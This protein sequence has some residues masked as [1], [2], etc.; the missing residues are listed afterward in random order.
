MKQTTEIS[1][2]AFSILS[3]ILI[4]MRH[5][6]KAAHLGDLGFAVLPFLHQL[7][8]LFDALFQ[9]VIHGRHLDGF[10]KIAVQRR[11]GHVGNVGD[12]FKSQLLIQIVLDVFQQPTKQNMFFEN[13]T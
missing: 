13:N 1:R 12:C 6:V 2:S 11:L 9:Y 5:V 10:Q 3:Q 4:H 7:L 8:P